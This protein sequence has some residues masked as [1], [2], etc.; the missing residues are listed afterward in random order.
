MKKILI[1]FSI[2]LLF[3]CS[4]NEFKLNYPADKQIVGLASP[5][6]LELGKA[7]VL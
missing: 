1:L 2:T 5:V 7:T 6:Q 3:A 4:N